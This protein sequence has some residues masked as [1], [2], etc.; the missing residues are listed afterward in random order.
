MKPTFHHRLVNNEFED[1]S[2][3]VR[4]MHEK[5]AF[6]FDAGHIDRLKPRDLLKITDLFVSHTHIDHFIGFGTLLRAALRRTNPLRVYGPENIIDCVEG[7]LRGYTW[8]VIEEY[9]LEIEVFG[10][11][12]DGIR[13]ASFYARDSFRRINRELKEFNGIA[14]REPPFT[15][16]AS[17]LSHGIPCLGFA[18][19]EDYHINIDKAELNNRGLPVGPW[20]GV[21]KDMIRANAAPDTKISVGTKE[22]TFSELATVAS[23]TRGQ[24][25][26]Y[27]TDISP[28]S[29]NI[30][31]AIELVRNSDTLYCEAYFLHEDMERAV[32]R[33]H[34]TAKMAGTIAK[35]AG[36]GNLIVMHH[37]PK[38][39]DDPDVIR[40][41]AM[42][43]FSG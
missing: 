34:L 1:P 12:A 43:E 22:L 36:V 29:D 37:S 11:T 28:D 21:L 19:E 41:E 39:K 6:L 10:L 5:R 40:E 23:I 4:M 25:V 18:L 24:K 35:E 38:Y 8:N 14:L 33:H 13:H 7:K 17:I 31:K 2:F 30:R 32:E 20:L 3:F 9:P 26:S 15:V 27:I 42:R 16:T